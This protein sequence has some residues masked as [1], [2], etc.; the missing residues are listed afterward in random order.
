MLS[1]GIILT[2]SPPRSPQTEADLKQKQAEARANQPDNNYPVTTGQLIGSTPLLNL[3]QYSLN[4]KVKICA[5]ASTS[6][7][8]AP[9]RTG[10]PSTSSVR[11]RRAAS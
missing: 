11:P 2:P 3:S 8:R 9:S 1:T 10:S 7:L 5:S 6:T 4:K